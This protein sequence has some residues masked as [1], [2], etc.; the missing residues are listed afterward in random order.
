MNNPQTKSMRCWFSTTGAI[1]T[2]I[3]GLLLLGAARSGRAKGNDQRT[4]EVPA[5]LEA[6]GSTH[7]DHFHVYAIGLQIYHWNTASNSWGNSVPDATLFDADGNIVGTHF[8]GPTWQ[9]LSGSYVK[10]ARIAG[11]TPDT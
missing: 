8:A 9:S 6:P 4:P 11:S 1:T 3:A 5:G 2:T 10:A 7:K